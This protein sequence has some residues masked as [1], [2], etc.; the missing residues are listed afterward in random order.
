MNFRKTAACITALVLAACSLTA[1]VTEE[2]SETPEKTTEATQTETEAAE[3][4]TEPKETEAAEPVIGKLVDD[5]F[6]VNYDGWVNR[7]ETT[8][9]YAADGEGHNDSRCMTVSGRNTGDDGAQSRKGFYIEDDTPCT[10][11]VFIKGSGAD[12]ARLMLSWKAGSSTEDKVIASA[13]ITGEDWTELTTE[14]TLPSGAKDPTVTIVTDSASDFSFDDFT[15]TG[16][17]EEN[18]S[19]AAEGLKDVYKDY[20]RFG[21][22]LS[23]DKLSNELAMDIVMKDFNSITCENEMKPDSTMFKAKSTDENVAVSLSAAASIMNFCAENGIAMRGH[24]LVWHSQ[25][26][27]WVFKEN[28][29]PDGEWVSKEKMNLRLESYIKNMFSAIEEQY[30]GV[31]LYGY[32]VCNECVSDSGGLREPGYGNGKSPWVQIYGD[33]SYIRQAFTFAKKYAPEGCS[34]FYNDYNEYMGQKMKDMATLCKELYDEGLLDGVGM[35]SHIGMS[36]PSVDDYKRALLVY[37][38]IGCE[39]QVTELDLDM[40]SGESKQAVK[41]AQIIRAIAETENVTSVTLWGCVDPNWRGADNA[42]LYG[43][44]Y[45]PKKAYTAVM[46]AM[47]GDGVV[48]VEPDKTSSKVGPFM[49]CGFEGDT[50]GWM[51]R[52][53]AAVMKNTQDAAE[54]KGSIFVT[55]RTDAWNGAAIDINGMVF[56]ND[57]CSLSAM[58]MQNTGSEE[59]LW[60]KL[61]YIDGDGN[62]QYASVAEVTA[63]KG[64]WVK[65]ENTEYTIPKDASAM[66]LYIETP[67]NLIDFYVDEAKGSVITPAAGGNAV[68]Q[69][70]KT[71]EKKTAAEID[72]T[73]IP[74]DAYA[75]RRINNDYGTVTKIT[76]HSTVT[77]VDRKCNVYLPPEYSEDK[78]YP[79]LYLLHGIGGTEDEWMGGSPN[80]IISNLIASGEAKEMIVVIPNIRASA[81]DGAGGDVFSEK[82]IKAFDNFINDLRDCLMP[83]VEENYSVLTGR[84]NTAIAGLSMGG[85]ESLYIGFEMQD[86]FGYIGAFSPAP[87]LE[88]PLAVADG[89]KAPFYVCVMTGDNDTV[90]YENPENYHKKLEGNKVE[91][92][93]YIVPGGHE[94]NVWKIGLYNFAKNIFNN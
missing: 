57:V 42:T 70:K 47:E 76:Y 13:E 81:D 80:E 54:G 63:P 17:I 78:K 38:E 36:Y 11:S 65:L 23:A 89:K 49:D 85:R 44:T 18:S 90:V 86:T 24:T 16:L 1:C 9:L 21:T 83:Y 2:P 64:E 62:A 22:C 66:Q 93:W 69:E 3:K 73:K 52:G 56:P 7:G 8:N 43:I 41:Y 14:F 72:N 61:Q 48:E 31:E 55:G 33:N 27:L 6:E 5:D 34:L 67:E 94:M 4:E 84:E 29:D 58:V 50:D 30:P 77:G 92:E 37:S 10:Y 87:G 39:I 45:N 68:T 91:H 60:M 51:G 35:Q 74:P 88:S 26:P 75:A 40:K 71:E 59:I 20:F 12:T 82:N 53:S 25:T 19:A 28:Y 79:V 15:V 46:Q 32:D